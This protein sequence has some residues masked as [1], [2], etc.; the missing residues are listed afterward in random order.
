M[1]VR[2]VAAAVV[3]AS[4]AN[5]LCCRHMS[6]LTAPMENIPT[7]TSRMSAKRARQVG[8]K[9][10][11]GLHCMRTGAK[12]ALRGT[13]LQP[14]RPR[15]VA[16]ARLDTTP[17]DA[18]RLTHL[19]ELVGWVAKPVARPSAPFVRVGITPEPMP[20]LAQS[21]S[22]VK[23]QKTGPRIARNA[24]PGVLVA[25]LVLQIL[26]LKWPIT[27]P[28]SCMTCVWRAMPAKVPAVQLARRAAL[29]ARMVNTRRVRAWE[30]AMSIWPCVRHARTAG[31]LRRPAGRASV[32]SA[33]PGGTQMRTVAMIGT[34]GVTTTLASSALLATFT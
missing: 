14:K 25:G 28:P 32:N 27:L 5:T 16:A 2:A 20:P 18:V 30:E 26:E 3:A 6:A 13:T 29:T 15:A 31:S 24:Q 12:T 19:S 17:M 33:T 4:R 7:A 10:P 22:L 1:E 8:T 21:A 9:M 34:T 23:Y 11:M